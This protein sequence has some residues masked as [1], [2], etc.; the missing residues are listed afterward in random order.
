MDECLNKLCRETDLKIILIV[1]VSIIVVCFIIDIKI[2]IAVSVVFLIVFSILLFN[3]KECYAPMN[4]C[5]VS[6]G[7]SASSGHSQNYLEGQ[8]NNEGA[9][10]YSTIENQ[11]GCDSSPYVPQPGVNPDKKQ[12]KLRNPDIV[13]GSDDESQTQY[14]SAKNY[15]QSDPVVPNL[16]YTKASDKCT[17]RKADC[18]IKFSNPLE[19]PVFTVGEKGYVSAN[20]K[21]AGPQNPKTRVPPMITRPMYSL[22]WRANSMIVPNIINAST[23]ENLHLSGYLSPEDIPRSKFE[24]VSNSEI[25]EDVIENYNSDAPAPVE[26]SKKTWSDMIDKEYGYSKTQFT[27]SGFPNNLPQGNCGRDPIMKDYNKNLFTQTVQPGVY[28]RDDVIEL[29][30][31]FLLRIT[32]Q[33]L[34]LNYQQL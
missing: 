20:Y 4:G 7:G 2:G 5:G 10:T 22:D 3:T 34:L 23:N 11:Q 15:F 30:M 29:T 24:D 13:L 19:L 26:Y 32:I 16:K 21:I 14:T 9:T 25:I 31:V 18:L 12:Y 17:T 1:L 28:Y 8:C 33:I 27:E 6:Y